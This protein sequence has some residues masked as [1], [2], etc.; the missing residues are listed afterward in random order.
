MPSFNR[1]ARVISRGA[2][3]L[4]RIATE[5]PGAL[6]A[7]SIIARLGVTAVDLTGSLTG[8]VPLTNPSLIVR[9]SSSALVAAREV[10]YRLS[11]TGGQ[12]FQPVSP[13]AEV[14]SSRT[15][16]W[17]VSLPDG[18][19]TSTPRPLASG[20]RIPGDAGRGEE[21]PRLFRW[22]GGDWAIWS[23]PMVH[24]RHGH[25]GQMAIARIE[26]EVAAP[27][28]P[29]LS[30]LDRVAEKNWVPVVDGDDLYVIHELAPKRVYAVQD[31]VLA[32]VTTIASSDRRLR[33]HSGSSAAIP[34]EGGWLIVTHRWA[35]TLPLAMPIPH[36]FYTHYFVWLSADYHTKAVSRPFRFEVR[37]VEFCAGLGADDESVYLSYGVNDSRAHMVRISR[38]EVQALLHRRRRPRRSGRWGSPITRG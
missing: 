16:V 21:D 14:S 13:G 28:I 19:P 30:P 5:L 11:R 2:L 37:G 26:D 20:P 15:W 27:T 35:P 36:R 29:L 31:S 10:G 7:P 18:R 34:W 3:R 22:R 25:S 6:V 33:R 38:G 9:D 32:P 12:L 8:P 24:E 17:T 1:A 23:I 4:Y